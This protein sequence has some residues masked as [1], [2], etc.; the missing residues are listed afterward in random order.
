MSNYKVNGKMLDKRIS[1][2]INKKREIARQSSQKEITEK[3]EE[4]Q[5]KIINDELRQLNTQKMLELKKQY[6]E[7]EQEVK[8]KQTQVEKKLYIVKKQN[9]PI[10]EKGEKGTITELIIKALE[11]PKIN[12][13]E[14]AVIMIK[15][16]KDDVIEQDLRRQLRNTISLIK[17]KNKKDFSNYIWING[18]YRI[19][20]ITQLTL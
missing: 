5:I 15:Q 3:Q 11:H 20:K 6:E 10:K 4:A 2:L 19:Q 9:K 13:E 17:N 18:E 7:R 16:W 8:Q 14:K 1:E 12:S